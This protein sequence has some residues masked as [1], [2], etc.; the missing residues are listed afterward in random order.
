MIT[1]RFK[2]YQISSRKCCT[3][4][5]SNDWDLGEHFFHGAS[6]CGACKQDLD[7][8]ERREREALAL[9]LY[10]KPGLISPQ[11]AQAV[12]LWLLIVAVATVAILRL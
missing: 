7:E 6:V 8:A 9:G 10:P 3:C 12:A 1:H 5:G 11:V 2:E 4:C